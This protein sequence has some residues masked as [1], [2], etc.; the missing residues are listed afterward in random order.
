MRRHSAHS[1]GFNFTC[2]FSIY[3]HSCNRCTFYHVWWFIFRKM[4][5]SLPVTRYP[6]LVMRSNI[7]I[8]KTGV[9]VL[10]GNQ[11]EDFERQETVLHD[12]TP[13][14]HQMLVNWKLSF[15]KLLVISISSSLGGYSFV[16]LRFCYVSPLKL[17]KKASFLFWRKWY[18]LFSTKLGQNFSFHML[19]KIRM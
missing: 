17:K 8:W 19:Q 15:I 11:R 3:T 9:T 10:I 12:I 2:S 18:Q 14:N 6:Q 1:K 16:N 5:T 7:K 13:S 4:N